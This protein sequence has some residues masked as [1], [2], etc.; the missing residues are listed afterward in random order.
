MAVQLDHGKDDDLKTQFVTREG[1]YRLMALAEYS[2]PNRVGYQSNQNNPQVRVSLVSLPLT[3]PNSALNNYQQT[4]IGLST[5][6]SIGQQP[7]PPSQQ[8]PPPPPQSSSTS[9]SLIAAT[10]NGQQQQLLDNLLM[11]QCGT[12]GIGG[13]RICFNFGKELY[14]YAYRGCKKVFF[15]EIF[16]VVHMT[17]DLV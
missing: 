15:I 7:L 1:T 5:V 8:P 3:T 2:R 14:V 9:S 4:G 17:D 10:A 6:A 13:D 16:Y 12:G 11:D